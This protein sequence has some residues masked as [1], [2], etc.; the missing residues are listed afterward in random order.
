MALPVLVPLEVDIINESLNTSVF[1]SL[2]KR[3][4]IVPVPK[5][6][7]PTAPKDY[8]PISILCSLSKV[9][10]AVVHKQLLAH[11]VEN[12]LLDA[13][14]SDFKMDHSTQTVLL[15]LVDDI[16]SATDKRMIT[17]LV[18]FDFSKAFDLVDHNLLLKKLNLMGCSDE[19]LLWFRSYLAG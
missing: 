17:I 18:L 14:K 11:L 2:W 10:E 3:A 8:R 5:I 9:L 19:V 12:E 15:R 6:K 4:L 13:R 1:P 7:K 16:R